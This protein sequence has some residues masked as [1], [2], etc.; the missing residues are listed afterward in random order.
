MLTA[1]WRTELARVFR[2]PF[3]PLTEAQ[4]DLR[5]RV[6]AQVT[7]QPHTFDMADWEGECGTTRCVGGWADYFMYGYVNID[8]VEVRAVR[9]LGLTDLEYFGPDE[10]SP[11]FTDTELGALARLN[12]LVNFPHQEK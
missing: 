7:A 3:T 6:L 11:L 8:G 10:N 4:R 5:A 2:D 1:T 12:K 9:N